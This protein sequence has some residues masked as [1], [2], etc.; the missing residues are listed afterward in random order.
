[1]RSGNQ[2][3]AGPGGQD[4]PAPQVGSRPAHGRAVLTRVHCGQGS[5]VSHDN[6]LALADPLR[7]C[8]FP[9]WK[10]QAASKQQPGNP[11]PPQEAAAAG[12]RRQSSDSTASSNYRSPY[13]QGGSQQGGGS[14]AGSHYGG[15]QVGCPLH[16]AL[17]SKI[18]FSAPNSNT[19]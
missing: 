4:Q 8:L 16:R 15:P 5:R 17:A 7:A 13:S 2:V 9:Q 14:Q 10:P 1:M 11:P 19:L 3:G 18:S 6:L 12:A